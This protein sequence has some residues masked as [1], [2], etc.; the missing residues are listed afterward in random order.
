MVTDVTISVPQAKSGISSI[1]AHMVA[2]SADAGPEITISLDSN[3]S[4]FGPSPKALTPPP[5]QQ[6]ILNAIWKIQPASLFRRLR[7]P[8]GLSLSASPSDLAQTIYWPALPAPICSPAPRFCEART[9]ISK[10]QIMPM[11]T[12]PRRS[13]RRTVISAPMLMPCWPA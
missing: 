6:T 7:H 1:K 13:Q 4:A 3:E 2:T 10:C 12:M 8:T 11:P 9:A 5:P